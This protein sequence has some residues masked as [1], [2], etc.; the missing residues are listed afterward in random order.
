MAQVLYKG[1]EWTRRITITDDDTGERTDLTG[2]TVT[3]EIRRRSSSGVLVSVESGSGI[4][5]LA[6]S[7]DTIGQ[8]DLVV[9]TSESAVLTADPHV[10]RILVDGQVVMPSTRLFVQAS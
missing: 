10:M 9:G 6:Q 1:I 4:T 2:K 3:F 7:G 5:H 8:A